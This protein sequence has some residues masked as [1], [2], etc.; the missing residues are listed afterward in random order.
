MTIKMIL[1]SFRDQFIG[2]IYI[3]S[4]YHSNWK[5]LSKLSIKHNSLFFNLE[6]NV[7]ISQNMIQWENGRTCS[8]DLQVLGLTME[9][10]VYCGPTATW[11]R[12][13]SYHGHE[14]YIDGFH[15]RRDVY[16]S[17]FYSSHLGWLLYIF[18]VRSSYLVC[19]SVMSRL[20]HRT[21]VLY[22]WKVINHNCTSSPT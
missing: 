16:L 14:V 4:L 11:A 21:K 20:N 10:K 19:L 1:D 3:E 9:N 22:M 12:I 6:K 7:E 5:V 15:F 18:V 2:P 17:K 13:I 8:N